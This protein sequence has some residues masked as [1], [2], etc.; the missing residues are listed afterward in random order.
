MPTNVRTS[1]S[2]DGV[3]DDAAPAAAPHDEAVGEGPEDPP[4]SPAGGAPAAA[5]ADPVGQSWEEARY[6]LE[7]QRGRG[8]CR[9]ADR[10]KRGGQ[11]APSS[12][13]VAVETNAV[14]CQDF[15]LVKLY[16]SVLSHTLVFG[17]L[18]MLMVMFGSSYVVLAAWGEKG[19]LPDEETKL[20][21]VMSGCFVPFGLVFTYA[22]DTFRSAT[23]HGG[24]LQYLGV[25]KTKISVNDDKVL[26]RWAYVFNTLA[27]M[28]IAAGIFVL[29]QPVTQ[30][31]GPTWCSASH[32]AWDAPVVFGNVM[33]GLGF[34][35]AA[36]VAAAMMLSLHV[37]ATL[38]ADA[39]AEVMNGVR[40]VS[41]SVQDGRWEAVETAALRLAKDTMPCLSDGWGK[42][43]A[44]S[45]VASWL[46]AF[47]I[48]A[49]ILLS[50]DIGRMLRASVFGGVIVCVPFAIGWPLASTS[51]QCK[52][53]M[54]HLNTKR[55][56]NL[57]EHGRLYALETA[58]RQLNDGKGMG[59]LVFGVVV[60]TRLLSQ[61]FLGI[62]S[63]ASTSIP[64]IFLLKPSDQTA[65][66]CAL[67]DSQAAAFQAM[68]TAINSTCVWNISVGADGVTVH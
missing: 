47:G 20:L 22:V 17:L 63:L 38:C 4:T 41:D 61:V 68:A 52:K 9:E 27:L 42:F 6:I 11:V 33:L 16:G 30:P 19:A 24:A 28:A 32:C 55:L 1:T 29:F 21:W 3:Q 26:T 31:V 62:F 66:S 45:F 35:L 10:D 46:F 25:G 18:A 65:P 8:C 54:E 57:S 49:E 67:T 59:F 23:A 64:M 53:L 7:M 34:V 51:T 43:V 48:L 50:T 12:W 15:G 36:P 60:D 58:L 37:A 13:S 44:C 14:V 5:G 39:I 2:K 40:T 56:N